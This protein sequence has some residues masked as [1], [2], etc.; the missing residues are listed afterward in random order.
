MTIYLTK[1]QRL[2]LIEVL[3]GKIGP[4][5]QALLLKLERA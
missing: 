2:Y 3:R 5:A 1:A 4:E